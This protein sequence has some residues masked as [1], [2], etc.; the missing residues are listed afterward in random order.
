M[1]VDQAGW[2][3]RISN[4]GHISQ[5]TAPNGT[6]LV[7][8]PAGDGT[9]NDPA[10][11]GLG[12]FGLHIAKP[13][14][15]PLT[16]RVWHVDTRHRDPRAGFV[17]RPFALS[18]SD[19]QRKVRVAVSLFAGWASGQRPVLSLDYR[20]RLGPGKVAVTV[21][22]TVLPAAEG[23]AVKEPKLTFGSLLATSTFV[24]VRDRGGRRLRRRWLGWYTDPRRRTL[25][26]EH[27]ARRSVVLSGLRGRVVL[28][29]HAADGGLPLEAWRQQAQTQTAT[30]MDGAEKRY[31]HCERLRGSWEL[32]RWSGTPTRA[33]VMLHAWTGGT[34]A[35]DCACAFRPFPPA[36]TTHRVHLA[37]TFKP[38]QKAK[39]GT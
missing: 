26:L 30:F 15:G 36:G 37:A 34:G 4:G 11:G 31:C 9:I 2:R 8:D 28:D 16:D 24:T 21:T 29:A 18:S 6:L 33:A 19:Q 7:D 3:Y 20:W 32:A 25:Q 17:C 38:R 39:E 27:G 14:A 13:G 23:L 1:M 5:V 35:Y 12:A 22:V 10:H